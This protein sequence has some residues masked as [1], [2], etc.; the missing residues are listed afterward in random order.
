MALCKQCGAWIENPRK[1]RKI[2]CDECYKTGKKTTCSCCGVI[3]YKQIK[4]PT[5]CTLLCPECSVKSKPTKCPQC[6]RYVRK[7]SDIKF[8]CPK[9]GYGKEKP[10][11]MLE[12][13]ELAR[14]EHL[15]YGQWVAKYEGRTAK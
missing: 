10:K 6:R 5:S 14:Q 4:K 13:N 2:Y 7:R 8:I 11:T 15:T 12:I 9:C 3:F 1:T